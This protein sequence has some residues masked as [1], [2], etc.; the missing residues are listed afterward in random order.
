MKIT[1]YINLYCSISLQLKQHVRVSKLSQRTKESQRCVG[2]LTN[3]QRRSQYWSRGC[4]PPWTSKHR[5][6]QEYIYFIPPG[7]KNWK[8]FEVEYQEHF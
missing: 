1:L 8:N 4:V 7:Y 5:R 6:G 2:K 3:L